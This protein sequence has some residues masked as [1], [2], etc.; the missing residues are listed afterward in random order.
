MNVKNDDDFLS[1]FSEYGDPVISSGVADF[2]ENST[3][4]VFP[5]ESLS[6]H[7][8]SN[9]V[10]DVEI[11]AWV[12]IWEAVDIVAFR[13]RE[14]RVNCRRYLAYITMKIRYFSL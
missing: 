8:H 10:D 6:L 4:T 7:I 12:L 3:E 1:V 14:L 5:D 2:I 13:N 11:V 9:C